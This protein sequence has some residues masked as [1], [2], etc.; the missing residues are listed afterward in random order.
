MDEKINILQCLIANRVFAS[1]HSALAKELGY[2][3]KMAIYRLME[4]KAAERTVDE[5]WKRIQDCYLVS[6]NTLYH[7]ARIFEGAKYGGNL[8]LSEM[9]REHPQWVEN[10]VTAFVNDFYD[11][12]SPEFQQ[13][14]IPFLK[15]LRKDEPEIFWG[16]V[17]LIY[18]RFKKIDLYKGDGKQAFC[19]LMEAL[20]QLLFTLYPERADAHE[21]SFNLKKLETN[22]NLYHALVNGIILFRRYTEADFTQTASRSMMLFNWGKRSFWHK[23]DGSYE[24]GSEIWLFVEQDFGRATNG[25]YIVLRLEA[26]KDI[27]TFELKDSLVFCFWTIDEEDDPPI[28]QASRGSGARREW[29]FYAYEYDEDKC[30]FSLNADPETGNLFGLPDALQ[31]INLEHPNGKDE[32]VWARILKMWDEHQ[33]CAVF[34]KAKEMLSERIELKDEYKLEDVQISRNKFTLVVDRQGELV[35]YELPIEAYDFLSEINPTKKILIVSHT[36]DN[37]IYVEW[38]DLGYS[39]RLS[40]FDIVE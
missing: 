39:I 27:Q 22:T 15:D 14:E 11:Y 29:C 3:G 24:Q 28:L 2:K 17:T 16:I 5:I 37:Q 8:L 4:G 23:P 7:L 10:F 26:G 40:E 36:D 12:F 34:Q 35:R 9:N 32:K 30:Q 20:D 19:Q 31:M 6:D 38:P 1:S 18:I 13:E 33:G 25:Y 21:V